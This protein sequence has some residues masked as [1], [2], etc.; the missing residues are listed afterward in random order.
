[1]GS[2]TTEWFGAELQARAI[3]LGTVELGLGIAGGRYSER[4]ILEGDSGEGVPITESDF[5]FGPLVSVRWVIDRPLAGSAVEVAL[6]W[7]VGLRDGDQYHLPALGAGLGW[8]S[9]AS[10]V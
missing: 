2:F 8:Y 10:P 4:R 3:R 1:M 9:V 5:T 6:R 7:Q